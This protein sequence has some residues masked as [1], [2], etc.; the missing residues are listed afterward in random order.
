MKQTDYFVMSPQLYQPGMPKNS[1]CDF[2]HF[3]MMK[4]VENKQILLYNR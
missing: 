1:G 2:K 3:Y 4:K